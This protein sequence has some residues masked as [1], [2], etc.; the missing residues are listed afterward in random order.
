MFYDVLST[1]VE[2]KVIRMIGFDNWFVVENIFGHKFCFSNA[3]IMN[4]VANGL[5]GELVLELQVSDLVE[6][7][8]K[9]W[10]RWDLV[11]VKICFFGVKEI[12][13][14]VNHEHIRI[15]KFLVEKL[16]KDYEYKL[17]VLCNE[18]YIN[19]NYAIARIQ[20][21]KPLVWDDDFEYYIVP[22]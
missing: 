4:V 2:R 11:Y 21:V 7:H 16:E 15:K 12:S 13:M 9:K 19:C 5:R 20:N 10:K 22:E 18:N 17:N 6:K 3:E 1:L 14:F 8:P